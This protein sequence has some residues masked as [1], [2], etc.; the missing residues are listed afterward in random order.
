MLW[1]LERWR[2]NFKDRHTNF[3]TPTFSSDEDGFNLERW[4]KTSIIKWTFVWPWT[5]EEEL[6]RPVCKL[7]DENVL[8][9][10]TDYFNEPE[11]WSPKCAKILHSSRKCLSGCCLI[12]QH[13]SS[14]AIRLQHRHPPGSFRATLSSPFPYNFWFP[15]RFE[16]VLMF[17]KDQVQFWVKCNFG[18][19]AISDQVQFG[20]GML[21]FHGRE[22]GCISC[23][24]PIDFISWTRLA[25][26]QG[27][28]MHHCIAR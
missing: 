19:R 7:G 8:H 20:S 2:K 17:S 18:P 11:L 13:R 6:S 21:N 24:S 25:Q 15:Q 14:L 3:N 1:T 26:S 5:L 16:F 28:F 22:E 27:N 4:R 10:I 23:V 12:G 9:V